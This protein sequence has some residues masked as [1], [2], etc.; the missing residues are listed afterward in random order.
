M[1]TPVVSL[2]GDSL[3]TRMGL[4]ILT[5]AGHP[6]WVTYDLNA[7]LETAVALAESGITEEVKQIIRT[8]F[9]QSEIT[10]GVGLAKELERAYLDIWQRHS[11]RPRTS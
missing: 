4:S 7:Y 6:E 1:G 9:L 5:A 2:T 11:E 10:D 8:D 3:K